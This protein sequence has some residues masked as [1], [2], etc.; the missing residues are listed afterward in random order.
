MI[1][2][3]DPSDDQSKPRVIEAIQKVGGQ[4]IHISPNAAGVR[5]ETDDQNELFV[6]VDLD[7]NVI[8]H[9]TRHECHHDKTIIHRAVELFIFDFK[10]R[11][12]L[13]K[14]S[15]AKDTQPGYWSTSVGGHVGKD[16]SYEVAMRREVK[17]ELGIEIPVKY[18]SKRVVY[19][20]D[21]TE[22]E[23][24]FI[25]N[26]DGPFHPHP[27]E[28]DE[29]KFFDKREIVFGVATNKLQLT[30]AALQNLKAIGVLP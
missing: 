17:E 21:E 28:I 16:E 1:A 27:H 22:M 9:K 10:G 6:V 15:M 12:L 26:F 5:V 25:A 2:L 3:I 29:V 18:T 11:I 14:R 24:L 13:Q 19:F 8:G 23:A 30:E 7:D 20:P 4:V